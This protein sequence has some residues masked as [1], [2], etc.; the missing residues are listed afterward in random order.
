MAPSLHW[1][2]WPMVLPQVI[3]LSGRTTEA[4]PTKQWLHY[5]FQISS[6]CEYSAQG[7]SSYMY[8]ISTHTGVC[9]QCSW[10]VAC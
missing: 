2:T 4:R 7:G 6:S 5:T 10:G 9:L 8:L 3:S 1:S